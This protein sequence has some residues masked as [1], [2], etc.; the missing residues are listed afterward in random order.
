MFS[1]LRNATDGHDLHTRRSFLYFV[2]ERPII[3]T[4]RYAAPSVEQN[5]GETSMIHTI[6]N[7]LI[8]IAA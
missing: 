2:K 8:Y 5:K 4:C 3:E 1:R 7:A 6:H